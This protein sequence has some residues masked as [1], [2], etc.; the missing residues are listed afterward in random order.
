MSAHIKTW[1]ERSNDDSRSNLRVDHMHEYM[2]SEI[3]ELRAALAQ[4]EAETIDMVC[5]KNC[6]FSG[7]NEDDSTPF[8]FTVGEDGSHKLKAVRLIGWRCYGPKQKE[9]AAHGDLHAD[10]SGLRVITGYECSRLDTGSCGCTAYCSGYFKRQE[11]IT[12]AAI[13]H[14]GA[15]NASDAK[16]W[17]MHLSLMAKNGHSTKAIGE[18]I[19]AV[20]AAIDAQDGEATCD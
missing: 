13:A 10:S 9:A 5:I 6:Q 16:R 3:S 11:A 7:S 12:S 18:T 14:P 19:N 15:A 2:R 17:R 1:Q 8:E 20:D 4:K